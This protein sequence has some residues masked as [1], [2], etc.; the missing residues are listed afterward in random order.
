MSRAKIIETAH[1]QLGVCENP[2][3]TN[4]NPYG[5]WYGFNGYAWC[6]MFVSWVYDK[7]G[8][9]LGKIDDAKG[10]RDCN[11]AYRYWKAHQELTRDPEAGEVS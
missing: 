4:K 6:A 2:A 9:P 7:A 8:Y 5:K 1:S 11:S 3:G 10:Y